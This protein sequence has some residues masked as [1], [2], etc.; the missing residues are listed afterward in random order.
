[1]NIKLVKASENIL[2]DDRNRALVTAEDAAGGGADQHAENA[3]Q[4]YLQFH[5]VSGSLR[6]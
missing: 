2:L 3:N 5:F 4:S 1:M 6:K